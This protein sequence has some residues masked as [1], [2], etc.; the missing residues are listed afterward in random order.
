LT[1]Q[2][3][4]DR[5]FE[6]IR[7][8]I[9][10]LTEEGAAL[11][12]ARQQRIAEI[13]EYLTAFVNQVE[14]LAQ[15]NFTT[16]DEGE[17]EKTLLHSPIFTR[18]V[19]SIPAPVFYKNPQGQ[20]LGCNQA[21]CALVGHSQ[22]EIVGNTIF[23]MAAKDTAL[24][25]QEA[26]HALL[27]QPGVLTYETVILVASGVYRDVIVSKASFV[28][29]QGK[30]IGLVGVLHDITDYKRT[31]EALK[32]RALQLELIN[33]VGQKI[34]AVLDLDVLLN[35]AAALIQQQFR[36]HHVAL[37]TYNPGENELVMR[38]RAGMFA[39]LFPPNHRMNLNQG[40]VGW[41]TKHGNKLIA[42]DVNQEPNYI[43]LYPQIIPTQSELAVPLKVGNVILGVLDVQSPN[44]NAFDENDVLVIETLADQIAIALD[45]ARLYEK[46]QS[47][48]TERKRMEQIIIR[49]ERLAAMGN[50]TA[51]L[52]HEIKNPL[53]SIRSHMDLVLDFPLEAE[54]RTEYLHVVS[55]ELDH[56]TEIIERMLNFT[57]PSENKPPRPVLI[58]DVVHRALNLA[59]K[60]MENAKIRVEVD[61][62][63][64]LPPVEVVPDQ[65]AQVVLN[66]LINS[67]E[68]IV[69]G[70]VVRIWAIEENNQMA[71][72]ISN[73]GPPIPEEH[74]EHLF[75]PFFTTKPSNSGLG[76]YVSHRILEIHEGSISV[77]NLS[78]PPGV[79][80]TLRLPLSTAPNLPF[81]G[82]GRNV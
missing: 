20:Y 78:D 17:S 6:A 10:N 11:P 74:L 67:T 52:A 36:Y 82:K 61:L 66:L 75:D 42:N 31:D 51:A 65:I 64:D 79:A 48:L 15:G 60:P 68:A 76:L 9:R 73:D 8:Q 72:T 57:R 43:N 4:Q 49:T 37:F 28:D 50:I 29:L 71:L 63:E 1:S 14:E 58:S 39:T 12:K 34:A 27:S 40:I 23:D 5:S 53:Q 81:P 13:Q 47:E 70:G 80:F 59:G 22:E 35:K 18:L 32:Q 2:F 69:N 54:E 7:Q 24:S 56:L 3:P 16:G 33:Q 46:A 21:F 55:Q 45:N 19:Q 26:D 44:L 38:A 62:P 30:I 41:V 77:T 25:N